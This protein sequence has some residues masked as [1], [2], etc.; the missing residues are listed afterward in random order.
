MSDG[1]TSRLYRSLVRD[2][3]IAAFA[4]GFN[5]FPGF[6][7]PDMFV[8]YAVPTPGHTPEELGKA[9][10]AEIDRLKTEDIT[11]EELKMIKTRVKADLLR[12]LDS[13]MGLAQQFATAQA[14]FGDWREYFHEVDRIDKVTKADIRRVANETFKDSNRVVGILDTAKPAGKEQE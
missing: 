9:I 10:H 12:S 8:F 13:N 3:K 5:D 6:K 14:V 2:K 4:G 11:D 7:Y 1:R